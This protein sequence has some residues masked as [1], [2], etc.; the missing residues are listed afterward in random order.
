MCFPSAAVVIFPPPDFGIH[1]LEE[2]KRVER[3][4]DHY[5][6]VFFLFVL[7]FFEHLV[8][9]MEKEM[10]THSS[11]L[12]WKSPWTESPSGLPSMGVRHNLMT[13]HAG[14]IYNTRAV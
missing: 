6:G 12:A 7:F 8:Y 13:E 3:R 1:R 11:I 10:A 9:I 5:K 4:N 2:R 14:S